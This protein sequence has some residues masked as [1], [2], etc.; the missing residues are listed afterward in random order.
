MTLLPS[1][2]GLNRYGLHVRLIPEEEAENVNKIMI[3]PSIDCQ[4]LILQ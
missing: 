2:S 4:E 3:H 1:T